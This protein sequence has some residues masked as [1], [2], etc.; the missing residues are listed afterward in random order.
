METRRGGQTSRQ[1]PRYCVVVCIYIYMYTLH[2]FIHIYT[3]Y[4]YASRLRLPPSSPLL[5]SLGAHAMFP[6]KPKL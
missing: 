6:L 5:P 2:L 4:V 3:C 1:V